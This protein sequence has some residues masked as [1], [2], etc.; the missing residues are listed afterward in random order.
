MATERKILR[1][2][3]CVQNVEQREL[4]RK[5]DRDRDRERERRKNNL[6]RNR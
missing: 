4:K 3:I 2:E 6:I 5:R 1:A